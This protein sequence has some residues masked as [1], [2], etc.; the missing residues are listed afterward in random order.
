MFS[1][2]RVPVTVD[3][4]IQLLPKL[5]GALHHYYSNNPKT[6]GT[7][8]N[9]ASFKTAAHAVRMIGGLSIRLKMIEIDKQ[10]DPDGLPGINWGR[11]LP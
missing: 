6:K 3:G 9:Y 2:E 11:L 4:F 7:P 5:R 1:R 10:V 8:F